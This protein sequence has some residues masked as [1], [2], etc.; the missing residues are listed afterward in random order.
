[1]SRTLGLLCSV[2][3]GMLFALGLGISGMTQPGKVVAFL[4]VMGAWD[5]SL[6]CVMIGAIATTLPAYRLIKRR[7]APLASAGFHWPKQTDI[8]RPLLVGAAL[9]GLGWGIAG[10]CPGPAIASVVTGATPVLVFVAAM[11]AGMGAASRLRPHP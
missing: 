9:F 7:S 11:A 1:M 6:A 10:F 2:A 5:P 3:L 8:D 4:D